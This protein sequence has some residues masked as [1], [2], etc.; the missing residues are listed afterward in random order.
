M[1][2]NMKLRPGNR[3]SQKPRQNLKDVKILLKNAT[4]NKQKAPA[5]NVEFYT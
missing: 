4:E 3:K 5:E 1:V 2:H